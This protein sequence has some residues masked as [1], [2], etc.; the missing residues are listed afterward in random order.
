MSFE[1]IKSKEVFTRK[2]HVCCWCG[3]IIGIGEK[4]QARTY[5][6]DGSLRSD[7]MHPECDVA[8][9]KVTKEQK[10]YS[11]EW[12]PGDYPRGGTESY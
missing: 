9:I 1:E 4:A 6:M 11:I 12:M 5:R 3:Q 8:S 10:P 7:H 2:K